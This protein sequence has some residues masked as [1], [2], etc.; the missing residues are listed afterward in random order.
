MRSETEQYYRSEHRKSGNAQYLSQLLTPL[1]VRDG[2]S[3]LD[4]GCGTGYVNGYLAESVSLQ[5]NLGFDLDPGAIRLARQLSPGAGHIGWFCASAEAVPLPDA[6]VDHV[7]CR[8]VLPLCNVAQ[9]IA[10]IARVLRP[11]GTAVLLLHPWPYYLRWLSVNPARWKR[12][13]LGVV[14]TGLGIWFNATGHQVQLRLGRHRI[15]QTFQTV[16]RVRSILRRRGM[17]I[18]RLARKPEFVV[19]AR[20]NG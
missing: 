9:V 4:V 5:Y 17:S 16:G 13:A 6:S 18:Y 7:I 14:S 12:S 10:E 11:G 19:Y 2:A 3:V 20:L 15:G 8:V 1:G